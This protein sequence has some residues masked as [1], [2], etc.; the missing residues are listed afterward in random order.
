MDHLGFLSNYLIVIDEGSLSAG[1]RRTGISQP[2]ISQQIATLEEYYGQKLLE[3]SKAG[4]RPTKAG[5]IV[6]K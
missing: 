3:R 4:V 2:A 1:A 6:C 5:Q